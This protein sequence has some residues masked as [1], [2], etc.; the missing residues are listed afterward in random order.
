MRNFTATSIRVTA[1]GYR[2][3]MCVLL[4]LLSASCGLQR[5]SSNEPSALI[6]ECQAELEERSFSHGRFDRIA[7]TLEDTYE[8]KRYNFFSKNATLSAWHSAPERALKEE[9]TVG[10]ALFAIDFDDFSPLTYEQCLEDYGIAIPQQV[11][12][13]NRMIIER[14]NTIV[15]YCRS[16]PDRYQPEPGMFAGTCGD[17]ISESTNDANNVER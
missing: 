14:Y 17:Y 7:A 3:S 11:H 13:E 4:L 8:D 2:L 12:D 1:I 10:A 15:S 16:L 9:S 5:Q 6:P